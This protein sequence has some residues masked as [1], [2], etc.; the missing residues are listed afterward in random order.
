MPED[1]QRTG[2]GSA[3]LHR[4][5]GRTRLR[6]DLWQLAGPMGSKPGAASK[7]GRGA[8][9]VAEL[10]RL[11]T[12]REPVMVGTVER[13]FQLAPECRTMQELRA[14]LLRERHTNVDA[15]LQ[16]SLR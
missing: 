13:A 5:A 14:R 9:A 8:F 11:R 16:G 1:G 3:V 4:R 15:H 7:G 10:D 6:L 2:A 12:A